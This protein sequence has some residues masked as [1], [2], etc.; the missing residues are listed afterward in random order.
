ML[1]NSIT[2]PNPD[3]VTASHPSG[4]Q[5]PS[6]VRWYPR[7]GR[8][9]GEFVHVSLKVFR[10]HAVVGSIVSPLQQ[11]PK[12]F[13][14][15]D[16]DLSVDIFPNR[17]LDDFMIGQ[18]LVGSMVIGFDI[19]DQSGFFGHFAKSFILNPLSVKGSLVYKSQKRCPRRGT[20]GLEEAWEGSA[21]GW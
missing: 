20:K 21:R 8:C 7:A 13:N 16:V 12:G 3:T 17:M 1:V 14:A 19:N 2:S 11:R 9:G 6:F 15:V 10:T 4:P 5:L 18:A